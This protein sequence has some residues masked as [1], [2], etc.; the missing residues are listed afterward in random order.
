LKLQDVSTSRFGIRFALWIAGIRPQRLGYAA[1][2][3]VC[4]R[5]ASLRSSEVVRSICANQW[6]V[7]GKR[8]T[9]D[10]LDAAARRVLINAGYSLYD[11]YHNLNNPGADAR[12][13]SFDAN[14]ERL[15]DRMRAAREGVVVVAPHLSNFDLTVRAAVRTGVRT[16]ILTL[17]NG[18]PAYHAQDLLRRS[19][20]LIVT[21]VSL[22]AVRMAVE[23][24]QDG[25]SVVTGIDR[26][27]H[28]SRYRPRFFGRATF[29]PVHH[30]YLAMKTG[31]PVCVI[32]VQ[33]TAN[34]VYAVGAS[35]FI[36]LE[37][38]PHDPEKILHNAEQVLNVAAG[39]IRRNPEQWSM[40][41]PVWPEALAEMKQAG[42]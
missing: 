39:Y 3:F 30:I 16:Q 1:T 8:L 5:L 9:R 14:T 40:F 33:R 7:S 11:F 12:L 18:A 38:N 42:L 37:G 29:L 34:G 21:P 24:L 19:P 17:N 35:D 28:T 41:F 20:N 36:R 4:N 10:E 22:H 13:V 15:L 6:V 27:L 31:A 32:A 23:R 25:G 2:R 26:P